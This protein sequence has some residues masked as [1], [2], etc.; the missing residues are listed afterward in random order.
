MKKVLV[1]GVIFLFVCV[2]I[3]PGIIANESLE[4]V[5]T[6]ME[7]ITVEICKIDRSSNHTILLT[8]EQVDKLENLINSF[9]IELDSADNL[10]ETETIFENTVVS[11]NDLG[12]I[13]KDI[14]IED[15]QQLVTGKKQDKRLVR[16]LKSLYNKHMDSSS[17]K[18]NF[19]CLI[20]GS[21]ENTYFQGPIARI[22]YDTWHSLIDYFW[23]Y[24][25]ILR[26]LTS[27]ISDILFL[28]LTL[29]GFFWG[30]KPLSFGYEIGFGCEYETPDITEYYPAEGWIFTLGLDKRNFFRGSFFGDIP[31]RQFL[32]ILFWCY[33]GA[34]GF[35]GIKIGL[36]GK[37]VYLGS[38]LLV[39]IRDA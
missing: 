14:K 22:T 3:Q 5:D 33:P 37:H 10:I 39:K 31:L 13:P 15:V 26:L 18:E 7:E 19:L 12:L 1:I 17:N 35:T 36:W 25:I 23:E 34:L 28:Y 4:K 16:I 32:S 24:E 2:A 6:N 8:K 21:T 29:G 20:A 9:E 30:I 27:I 11:L 38:A